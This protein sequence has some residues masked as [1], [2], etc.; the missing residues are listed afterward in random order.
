MLIGE[1]VLK[2]LLKVCVR[3]RLMLEMMQ[4]SDF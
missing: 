1:D 2:M 3:V 4:A